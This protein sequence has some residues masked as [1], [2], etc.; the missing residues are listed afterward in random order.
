M[1]MYFI[2]VHSLLLD[3]NTKQNDIDVGEGLLK[4]SRDNISRREMTADRVLQ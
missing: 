3:N 1:I 2:I 4:G